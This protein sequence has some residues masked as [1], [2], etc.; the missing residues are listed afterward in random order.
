MPPVAVTA[1]RDVRSATEFGPVC[2]QHTPDIRNESVALGV[3]SM[4]RLKNLREIIPKL[5]NQSE[6]CLYLN[7]YAPSQSKLE[8][9]SVYINIPVY[10]CK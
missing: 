10:A 6:D 7:L 4:G 9:I 1:W 8:S 5:A 3:M 2:P